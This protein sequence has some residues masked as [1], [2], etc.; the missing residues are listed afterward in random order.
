M[1]AAASG[2]FSYGLDDEQRKDELA[3]LIYKR[4]M[5]ATSDTFLL[6]SILDMTAGNG[7]LMVGVSIFNK[8]LQSAIQT[9]YVAP[10]V[11][12]DDETTIQDLYS[13][14]AIFAKNVYGPAKT[15]SVVY[16]EF[17]IDN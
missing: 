1:G 5:M 4:W 15:F 16:N 2:I 14:S 8:A 3:Q 9:A 12:I 17:A 6:K 11:L 7:S 10:M 13:A